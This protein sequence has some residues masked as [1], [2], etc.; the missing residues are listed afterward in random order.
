VHGQEN[1]GALKM[2]IKQQENVRIADIVQDSIVDGQGIRL[3]VFMQGCPHH[4]PGCHN[5]ATHDP[6]GG[7]EITVDEI[8]A[9]K[10]GRQDRPVVDQRMKKVTVE[11]F[12]ETYTVEKYGV[13]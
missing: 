3:T 2:A 5:P 12:G 4:C 10:T 9:T 7:R 11:T 8:A 13:R 6:H 1:E